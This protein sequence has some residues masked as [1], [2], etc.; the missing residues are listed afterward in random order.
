[1]NAE[2]DNNRIFLNKEV[3]KALVSYLDAKDLDPKTKSKY[4]EFFHKFSNVHGE[5]NQETIDQFLKFNNSSPAR[6]MLRNLITAI[7]RWDFPQEMLGALARLDIPKRTGRKEKKAPLFLT[8]KELEYLI[9][10]MVGDSIIDERNRLCILTQWWGGLRI[11]E[12][13]GIS[14]NDLEL[15]NYDKNKEFQRIKIRSETAKGKKEG[16]C[17]IPSDVYYR[18]TQYI[19][20]RVQMSKTFAQRLDSGGNI[21]NFSNS[22]YYKLVTKKTKQILGRAYNPH[23]LRHGRATDLIQKGVSLDKVKEILRHADISST[24]I[25]VHLADSDIEKSLR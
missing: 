20:K 10:R 4:L 6:A 23:S 5:L 3:E 19:N 24:Q 7:G 2:Q 16:Y 13:L 11:S 8:F 14:L 25:Y 1:M 21:W 15:E 22:A 17:Y 18:I 12:V 9:S